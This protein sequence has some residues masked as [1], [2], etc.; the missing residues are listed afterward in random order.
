MRP[1]RPCLNR[2][3]A[4][5]TK[6]PASVNFN[7]IDVPIA[8]KPIVEG[9]PLAI[10]R[11]A[12]RTA[13]SWQGGQLCLIRSIALGTPNRVIAGPIGRENNPLPIG[14]ELRTLVVSRRKNKPSG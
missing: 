4:R 12:R 3:V 10:G 5:Q 7:R 11:P 8:A 6:E 9:Y 14:G 2:R 13:V 1:T